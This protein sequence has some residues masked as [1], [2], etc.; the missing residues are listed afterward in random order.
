MYVQVQ[1]Y[2]PYAANVCSIDIAFT[3][4]SMVAHGYLWWII[5][6]DSKLAVVRT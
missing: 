1:L 6:N 4:T 2:N 3:L 5:P